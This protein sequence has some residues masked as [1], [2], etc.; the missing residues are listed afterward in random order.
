[1]TQD[2][3]FRHKIDRAIYFDFYE[4]FMIEGV[5]SYNGWFRHMERNIVYPD[6]CMD[7]INEAINWF[8]RQQAFEI[9]AQ[10]SLRK[11]ELLN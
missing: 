6:R 2:E 9:C 11:R 10:I 1:M 3:Q 8:E 4:Q 5:E 7:N